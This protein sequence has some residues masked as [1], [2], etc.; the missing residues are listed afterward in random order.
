[1]KTFIL[2]WNPSISSY[3]LDDFQRELEEISNEYNYMNWSVW[4]HEKASAGD[5]FFMVRCGNGKTGICMSG[6]FSSNPY[7]DEDWSGKGRVTYYMDL[8]PD[9]MIHP[10][11]LPILSTIELINAI[12]SFDW[13]GGHS[14][15][16]LDEKNAEKL[17]KLWKK[18]TEKNEGIFIP[19]AFRQ[20]VNPSDYVRQDNNTLYCY[21]SFSVEGKIHLYDE[22]KLFDTLE[23]VQKYALN[24]YEIDIANGFKIA[25]KFENIKDENQ[26]RFFAI[27]PQFLSLNIPLNYFEL[28]KGQYDEENIIT[29]IIYCLVKY[30]NEKLSS[31]LRQGFSHDVIDAVKALLPVDGETE[32]QNIKRIA[33]NKIAKSLKKDML[34]EELNIRKLNTITV[35]D[36]PRL[37]KALKNWI[38]LNKK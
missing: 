33:D 12:P 22:N 31:F 7:R 37:D 11:Y 21:L 28:I 19:R 34:Y 30:G 13:N 1:M 32:E 35:E 29:I 38:A 10:E 5:R 27:L 6:Y 17:E 26:E 14:G 3:K 16:L 2:F 8:E 4:E 36:V 25:F 20:E 24:T 18:F 15:R 9:V 23:E